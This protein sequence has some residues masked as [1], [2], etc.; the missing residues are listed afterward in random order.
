[1][2]LGEQNF[3]RNE[4][5]CHAID[6]PT[7][8]YMK[9]TPSLAS[10][11]GLLLIVANANAQSAFPPTLDDP[12]YAAVLPRPGAYFDP[13]H[14]GTGMFVD[15]RTDGSVFIHLAVYDSE[16][17]PTWYAVQDRFV[18]QFAYAT[19]GDGSIDSN[20]WYVADGIGYVDA[21]VYRASGGQCLGCAYTAPPIEVASELGDVRLT[22]TN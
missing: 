6:N 5:G 1:M 12:Y 7:E 19:H 2:S 3:G 21:P 13:D 18:P 22:W 15:V 20:R 17:K 8:R 11:L 14:P 16:G 10:A 4:P 9:T